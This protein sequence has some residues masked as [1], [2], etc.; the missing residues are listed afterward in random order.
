MAPSRCECNSVDGFREGLH[1]FEAMEDADDR[2]D[3]ARV[4]VE[5]GCLVKAA[6]VPAEY[7][8]M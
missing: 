2:L 6:I 4:L 1:V 3:G 5:E 7:I 8:P